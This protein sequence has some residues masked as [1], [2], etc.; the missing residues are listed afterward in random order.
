MVSSNALGKVCNE[1]NLLAEFGD[2]IQE[3]SFDADL[4]FVVLQLVFEAADLGFYS[5]QLILCQI[6]NLKI[7]Q[8]P[9]TT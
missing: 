3:E 2:Q 8:W 1:G 9:D 7:D 4:W 5:A 6:V